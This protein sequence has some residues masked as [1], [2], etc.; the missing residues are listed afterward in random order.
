M[1]LRMTGVIAIAVFLVTEGEE[2][3]LGG[4]E[5]METELEIGAS[6]GEFGF[7]LAYGH[8]RGN[9]AGSELGISFEFLLGQMEDLREDTVARGV[10]RRAALAF[11]SAGSGRFLSIGAIGSEAALG[12]GALG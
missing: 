4:G 6:A 1:R 7:G 12:D 2:I 11:G 8:E 9:V 3:V 10:E 5:A